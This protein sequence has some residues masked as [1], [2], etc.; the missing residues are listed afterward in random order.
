MHLPLEGVA[1]L[2]SLEVAAGALPAG[3][4]SPQSPVGIAI[5]ET[6]PELMFKRPAG[7]RCDRRGGAAHGGSRRRPACRWPIAD[8][9]DPTSR[10]TCRSSRPLGPSAQ[11]RCSVVRRPDRRPGREAHASRDE[12]RRLEAL[13]PFE[14]KTH[15]IEMAT[16]ARLEHRTPLLD[17]GRG[18]P[19]WIATE[20]REAFFALGTFALTEARRTWDAPGL[21]GMPEELGISERFRAWVAAAAAHPG[22]APLV[23]VVDYGIERLRRRRVG[24]RAR[25]RH[26]RRP[27]PGTRSH[28]RA[29]RAGRARV[30]DR[31]DVRA[32]RARRAVR[33][34]RRRGRHRG[35]VLH[36]RQP[37]GEP[38][39]RT[40]RHRRADGARRSRRTS[41]SRGS[42]ATATRSSSSTRT[43][44]ATTAARRGSS[45]TPR[46]TSSPTRRCG[47]CS[48][49][50]LR[51][52]RR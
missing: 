43:R 1:Q 47:R 36:L 35:D 34:L 15:L 40:G 49:S 46:S 2:M 41:R 52:R 9:P 33:P 50:T 22:V 30:P 14:L 10:G 13:S 29:R 11:L 7:L 26:H 45:P 18:N 19:N 23:R 24:L 42:T 12:E 31:G 39:A 3:A 8:R 25:R 20:P 44:T 5:W 51:T 37:R 27:L 16:A 28:A 21:A 6:E 48:S 32:G 38:A 4:V 17:A